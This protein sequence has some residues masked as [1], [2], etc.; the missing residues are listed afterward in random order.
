MKCL[1]VERCNLTVLKGVYQ[2]ECFGA[3]PLLSKNILVKAVE[4]A[5]RAK[6]LV[7]KQAASICR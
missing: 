5:Q 1:S 6:E 4:V 3:L 2:N 7:I